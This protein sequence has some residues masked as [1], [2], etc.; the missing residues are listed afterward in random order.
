M[1][2]LLPALDWLKWVLTLLLALGPG[3]ALLAFFPQRRR[4]DYTQSATLVIGLALAAWP[5][6]LAWLQALGIALSAWG[7]LSISITSWLIGLWVLRPWKQATALR[8]DLSRAAL[9]GVVLIVAVM[10]VAALRSAVV[11]PGS[12][13][14]HH[15]LITQMISE[16]GMLPDNYAPYAPLV[17]FTYHFGFHTWAAVLSLLS[18]LSPVVVVPITAQVLAAFA[19]LSVAFLAER[20]MNQKWVAASSALIAG[21]ISVFPAYYIN[22][23]RYT[24]LTGLVLLPIFLGVVWQWAMTERAWRFVP[25]IGLLAAGIVLAHYRVTLMTASAVVILIGLNGL[26][27]RWRLA[28]WGQVIGRLIAAAVI[29]GGLIGPWVWHVFISLRQ[30][31]PIEM[32]IIKPV[33]FQL[34]RLGPYVLNYPTNLVFLGLLLVAL[35]AGWLRRQ[36]VVISLSLWVVVMWVLSGPRL[37][38]AFMDTISVV[39]SLYIPA[40]IIIGW[41]LV[42]C[43]MWLARRWPA[44]RWVMSAGLIGLAAWGAVTIANIVEVNA[45]YVQPDDLPAMAWIRNNL[46]ASARFMVNT[47]HF[48]YSDNYVLG[49]DA[50]YWLPLLAGR[51]AITAPM[52][53]TAERAA[54]PDFGE[55]LVAFDRLNGQLTT[56]EA[57]ALLQKEGI[58]HVYVGQRGGPIVAAELL[59]SSNFKLV[60]QNRGAYVFAVDTSAL[61]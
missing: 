20:M 40:S 29:A 44:T 17:S 50:G 37:A 23:G 26:F 42:A 41:F 43:G 14:Y 24:Q 53:Y 3:L 52:I 61:R 1:I 33:F 59:K 6:G 51:T 16:R 36:R 28:E 48:A 12:D 19:A 56:P 18:G 58:T 35:I 25:F 21:L 31:Y 27:A 30:G 49:S 54:W 13:A 8:F 47:F 45:P 10:G 22:W 5:I 46:P 57:L 39:I 38:G 34:D 60:Y 32:G 15:T 9:W 55:R 11:G 7:V 2:T 4:L